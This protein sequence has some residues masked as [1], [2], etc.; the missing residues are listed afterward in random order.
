MQFVGVVSAGRNLDV[1]EVKKIA[2]GRIY[3]GKQAVEAGLVDQLGYLE[4][5]II[6]AKK[7]AGIEEAT[8]VR[9]KRL[10]GFAE[11]FGMLCLK[12]SQK[13]TITLDISS[14][15]DQGIAKPMYLWNGQSTGN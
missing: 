5:A 3:T 14:M 15:P 9:Y 11:L 13:N 6:M 1:E 8:V 2:D 4:D 7:T 10:Y 12:L